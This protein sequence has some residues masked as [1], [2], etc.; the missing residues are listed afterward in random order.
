MA[1][2]ATTVPSL[3]SATWVESAGRCSTASTCTSRC[4]GAVQRDA[5]GCA[6]RHRGPRAEGT[7][8]TGLTI[9]GPERVLA[10]RLRVSVEPRLNTG[11]PCV[12]GPRLAR[13]LRSSALSLGRPRI[14]IARCAGICEAFATAP[15]VTERFAGAVPPTDAGVGFT[16]WR[17]P[18]CHVAPGVVV[19]PRSREFQRSRLGVYLLES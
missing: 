11:L 2:F 5:R 17:Q 6:G 1:A 4:R 15:A 10:G 18:I 9:T 3:A 13:V 12:H 16:A 14:G 7:A 8:S 19:P